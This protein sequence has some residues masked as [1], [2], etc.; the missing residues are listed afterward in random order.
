[1]SE[2]HS[3]EI[4]NAQ[5]GVDDAHC[6]IDDLEGIHSSTIFL[7][8][9]KLDS[10]PNRSFNVVPYAFAFLHNLARHFGN[11]VTLSPVGKPVRI[12]I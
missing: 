7:N 11:D 8:I 9:Y 6:S 12:P 1:M 4:K 3:V 2:S 5:C 10:V